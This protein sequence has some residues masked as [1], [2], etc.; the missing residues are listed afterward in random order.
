MLEYFSR[1][2]IPPTTAVWTAVGVLAWYTICKCIYNLYFHPLSK[3]PGP[4]LA[5]IGFWYEFY[6]DVIKDGT[7]IWEIERMHRK[8]GK[9]PNIHHLTMSKERRT[10]SFVKGPIVRITPREL[11]IRDPQYYSTIYSG[12]SRRVNKDPA[13]VGGFSIPTSVVATIEHELHRARRGYLNPYFSKR[14]IVSI[15]PVIHE[16]IGKFCMRLEKAMH[17]GEVISLDGAFSALTA[18]VLS[19]RLYGH[20]FDYLGLKDFRFVVRDAFL[21]TSLVYH[22]ARFFPILVK[23]LKCLPTPMIR[24][25]MPSVADLLELRE[26][27]KR[28][29]IESFK[30]K[31]TTESKSVIVGSLGNPD[32]PAEE[33][34]IDRLLD[35]STAILFAGAETTSRALAVTMFYLL[36]NKP[37]LKRLCDELDTLPSR[38]DNAYSLAQLEALPFLVSFPENR[39]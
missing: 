11:H 8:Y 20:H 9:E 12:G 15:E 39:W 22:L 25:I 2:E 7:Y 10:D 30:E 37:Q 27:I 6:Y 33:R 26:E 3:F 14:S 16:R 24:L 13:A 19:L 21:G 17:Q 23:I 1:M 34:S 36:N 28:N 5:A 32:I 18:D 35:E 38:P 31:S 29:G 4:K